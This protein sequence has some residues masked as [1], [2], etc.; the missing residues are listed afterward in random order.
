MCA[1]SFVYGQA[2]LNP[3]PGPPQPTGQIRVNAVAIT[4]PLV[5]NSPGA[6]ILTSDITGVIGQNG[7][8]IESNDVVIDLNGFRLVGVP[9]S[10]DGVLVNGAFERITVHNG[11]VSN[12]GEDGIDADTASFSQ[13]YELK[14]SDNGA[15]GLASGVGSSV[16]DCVA[17]NNEFGIGVSNQSRVRD[18]TAI[19]NA[20]DGLFGGF[21]T[22]FTRCTSTNNTFGIRAPFGM[23][24]VTQCMLTNNS[25]GIQVAGAVVKDCTVM[26]STGTGIDL[27]AFSAEGSLVTGCVVFGGITG[28]STRNDSYVA[29]NLVEAVSGV[30]ISV[31]TNCRIV[32]NTV[33]NCG[34]VGI[35]LPSAGGS[36][37]GSLMIQNSA[38]NN[39]GGDYAT[40]SGNTFGAIV[41]PGTLSSNP[42][43]NISF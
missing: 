23:V 27:G 15:V 39:A 34:G 28:I 26:D 13:Y 17:E 41:G 14:L 3:P 22:Q 6:Y 16:Y 11:T 35:S 19:G 37:T 2:T 4:I 43:A 9:G 36:G 29:D 8:V 20:I 42:W 30:G 10:L 18:C 12:W 5:I 7:I 38:S 24:I 32:G 31:G 25:T 21:D 40:G 33:V 1:A